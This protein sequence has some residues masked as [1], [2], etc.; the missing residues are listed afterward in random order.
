MHAA[1]SASRQ[2]LRRV[3]AVAVD[4]DE[5]AGE[6]VPHHVGAD[7]VERTRLRGDDPVV[8]DAA[9]RER[10]DAERV[11]ERDE[12]AV[13]D[14][15]DRVGALE[16]PHRPPRRPRGAAPGRVRAAPRSPRCRTSTRDAPRRRSTRRGAAPGR[17]GCRCGRA[18]RCGPRRGG[19]AAAR[20]TSR[21]HPWSSTA[22][23]RSRRRP[24]APRASPRRTPVAR[25][26]SPAAP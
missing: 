2:R 15:D 22:C 19:R 23:G 17:R 4:P 16:P 25:G 3:A 13:R 6:H 20:S 8:A 12:R 7:E 5:L 18:P 14:R 9:E 24:G 1:P 21:R 11:A 10:P 26:P